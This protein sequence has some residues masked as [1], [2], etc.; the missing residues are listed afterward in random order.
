ML[1]LS[2]ARVGASRSRGP[3]ARSRKLS[4][5]LQT[6]ATVTGLAAADCRLASVSAICGSSSFGAS[7]VAISG[8][9]AAPCLGAVEVQVAVKPEGAQRGRVVGAR[10]DRAAADQRKCQQARRR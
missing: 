10:A 6:S 9:R 5:T 3:V 1:V 2:L 4:E 7:R 8:H